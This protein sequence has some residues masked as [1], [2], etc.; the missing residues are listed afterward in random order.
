MRVSGALSVRL[1]MV[2]QRGRD[3]SAGGPARGVAQWATVTAPLSVSGG[4]LSLIN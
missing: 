1:N 3:G 4:R 2:E